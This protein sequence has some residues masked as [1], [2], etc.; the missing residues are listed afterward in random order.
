MSEQ[1]VIQDVNPNDA[2]GGGGCL[3]SESKVEDCKPP[4]AVFFPTTTESNLS[5][6]VVAC[7]RCLLSASQACI[8]L[9]GE[10]SIDV[11]VVP[12]TNDE[13]DALVEELEESEDDVPQL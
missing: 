8:A 5:P 6:H 13:I 4:Y 3:C 9:G 7:Q 11:G 2:V 10:S 1:Y 12:A